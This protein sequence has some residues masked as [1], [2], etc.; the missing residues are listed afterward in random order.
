MP[1]RISGDIFF[2]VYANQYR[3]LLRGTGALLLL[4]GILFVLRKKH[5]AFRRAI[6]LLLMCYVAGILYFTLFARRP[7]P[8]SRSILPIPFTALRKAV[9]LEGGMHIASKDSLYQI[10][11]N[12]MLFVPLGFLLPMVIGK[13][14]YL[15]AAA[16]GFG[17]SLL[18]ECLQY[19]LGAGTAETDDLMHNTLGTLLGCGLQYGLASLTARMGQPRKETDKEQDHDR[20]L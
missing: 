1:Y 5:V 2:S 14:P 12:L 16:L 15:R 6:G 20:N 19:L 7:N 18:I 10:F 9:S 13:R 3:P 11:L 4:S 8:A 17:L